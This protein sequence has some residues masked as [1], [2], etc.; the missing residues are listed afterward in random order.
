M[1]SP[2]TTTTLIARIPYLNVE[3]FYHRFSATGYELID[4][5]PRELGEEA[6]RGRIACGPMSAV[7]YFRLE[8]DFEPL[9]PFGISTAGP[10]YSVLLFS[11]KP[12]PELHGGTIAVTGETSTSIRLLMMLLSER[13]E[14]RPAVYRRGTDGEADAYLWIGDEALRRGSR[15]DFPVVLDLSQAWWEWQGL[16]FVFAVWAVRRSLPL[17]EKKVLAM[18]FEDAFY[19]GVKEIPAIARERSA[20]LGVSPEFLEQYLRNFRYRL[21]PDDREGLDTFRR[22]LDRDPESR[23]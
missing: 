20:Q 11:R 6:A 23:S 14:I 8:K 19:E 3:P 12:V 17:E 4:L 13:F 9:G 16:P 15:T 18:R 7:D 21:G 2:S 10:S 5:P 22:M 1:S